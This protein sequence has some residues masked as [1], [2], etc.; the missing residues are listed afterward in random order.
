[1]DSQGN[2]HPEVSV[3]ITIRHSILEEYS[4]TIRHLANDPSPEAKREALSV[5]IKN[6]NDCIKGLLK[7]TKNCRKFKKI[8]NIYEIAQKMYYFNGD[9]KFII[10]Q[11]YYTS[12]MCMFYRTP[13][14]SVNSSIDT[15]NHK[16]HHQLKNNI[17][18]YITSLSDYKYASKEIQCEFIEKYLYN[19]NLNKQ[20]NNDEI[21]EEVENILNITGE[22]TQ[23]M[24]SDDGIKISYRESMFWFDCSHLVR[25]KSVLAPDYNKKNN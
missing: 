13:D 25:L 7:F 8:K 24:D 12:E 20:I 9:F 22:L 16:S 2:I 19:K 10:D 18:N 4:Q 5:F 14:F 1:M 15:L 6:V 17:Y 11:L 21:Y 23:F 3:G